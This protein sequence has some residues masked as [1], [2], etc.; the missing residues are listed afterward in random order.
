MCH[1]FVA[2]G[3]IHAGGISPAEYGFQPKNGKRTHL[4]GVLP[5]ERVLCHPFLANGHIHAGGISPAEY[6]SQP[7]NGKRTHLPGVLPQATVKEAFGHR[8]NAKGA[9]SKRA[10]RV[11]KVEKAQLQDLGF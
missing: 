7:K 5:Q 3:H 1:P 4:P 9:A 10:L 2:N 11:T 8:F 6:G